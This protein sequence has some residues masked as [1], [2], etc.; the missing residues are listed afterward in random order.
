MEIEKNEANQWMPIHPFHRDCQ[1]ELW[2]TIFDSLLNLDEVAN[3]AIGS[4]PH[5]IRQLR[6]RIDEY[7]LHEK[8]RLRAALKEQHT[9]ILENTNLLLP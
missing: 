8:S 7:V 3:S 4:R 1:K 6:S 5:S 2:T 9:M